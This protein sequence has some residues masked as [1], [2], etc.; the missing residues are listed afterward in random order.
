[1]DI[2][3]V[4]PRMLWG[5]GETRVDVNMIGPW[6]LWEIDEVLVDKKLDEV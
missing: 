6:M 5:L 4:G 1:M 2:N 3:V